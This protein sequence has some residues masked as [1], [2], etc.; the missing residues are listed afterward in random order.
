MKFYAIFALLVFAGCQ[1]TSLE[2]GVYK[3]DAQSFE[4]L[5]ER[6][7]KIDGKPYHYS[8]G[9]FTLWLPNQT[10]YL[11]REENR[12]T[13]SSSKVEPGNN[14]PDMSGVYQRQEPQAEAVMPLDQQ[15][16]QLKA[17]GDY[18][19]ARLSKLINAHKTLNQQIDEKT[20]KLKDMGVKSSNDLSPESK[21]LAQEI[22]ALVKEREKVMKAQDD[23]MAKI[24]AIQAALQSFVPEKSIDEILA[25]TPEKN[26]VESIEANEILNNQLQGK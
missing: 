19:T 8:C 9:E 14:L 10:Y 20:K 3:S 21:P 15:V 1:Q 25:N 23:T 5:S 18:H 16:T 17:N 7:I 2:K 22:V 13:L 4:V 24:K 12:L 11:D 26:P 6:M